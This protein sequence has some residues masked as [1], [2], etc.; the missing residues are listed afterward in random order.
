M[1]RILILGASG[2]VGGHLAPR[3]AAEGFEVR[4]AARRVD[5]LNARGWDG[6]ECVRA[7]ALDPASLRDVLSD[8]DVAYYLVHSMASGGN[9][10]DLDRRAAANF[11]D[12]AAN[13]GVKRTIYLG[14]IQP[15]DGASPHLASR[16]ETGEVL[17]SGPVPVTELRAGI[18]VGPGSAAFEV[19][20]DL[21]YHLPVMLAPRWVSSRSQPIGLDDLLDYLVGLLRLDDDGASHV[22]DAVGP[23]TLS[24]GDLLRQFGEVVGRTVRIVP[25]PVLTPR[26]SSYWLDLVTAVP[27]SIARPLIDGLKHDLISERPYELQELIPIRQQTYREAVKQAMDQ[28]ESA[29]LTIRWTEGGF[30]YRRQRHDVSWY[31]KSVRVT[32]RS[33]RPA[34]EVWRDI[35]SIGADR[36]WYFATWIWKLRGLIDRAI[37][38]VGMRRGRRHPTDCGLTIRSTSGASQRSSRAAASRS[39][40]R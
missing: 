22:Y 38:G 7:D 4:A 18:V 25:L 26:L 23:E 5:A 37:G 34:E 17:R 21:V 20:R 29:D 8:I 19:I 1:T 10:S 6:V 31:D 32:V 24:Y 15:S 28:E 39:W 9:F 14:G 35:S 30:R 11:R 40:R 12:A 3:L 27:A 2:Y 13:A 16:M 33:E 36:G